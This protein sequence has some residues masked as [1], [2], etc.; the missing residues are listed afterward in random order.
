MI[1][2]I[3]THTF[4]DKIASSVI[5]Q[6]KSQS[7]TVPFTDG[8]AC[9]LAASM[10][11]A[12]V[13]LS[14]I[15]S[16]ATSPKQVEHI[17]NSSLENNKSTPE[18][19]LLFFGCI[20]PD[21]PGWEKELHRIHEA[22]LAGIKIH[23]VYQRTAL[24]DEKFLR[25]LRLC[26]ELDLIVIAHM[27]IDIG[28]PDLSF[29]T[30]EMARNALDK[31]GPFKLVLAHM[32]GWREWDRAE[33]MLADTPAFLD[34]SFS[35]GVMTPLDDGYYAPEDLLLM[36][37]EEF[38]GMA[39]AFGTDR[40]LFGTDSPWSP[41]KESIEWIRSLPLSEKEKAAILGGNAGK[42]LGV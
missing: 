5:N 13:D 20:H 34:T 33:K 40:L 26:A 30:P 6:L 25:I 21:Y 31:I 7:H 42:L 2:D 12:G 19:G 39:K 32:G 16:V 35:T 15:L 23:P 14:V 4:P 24:D 28:Y 17:N 22:G 41:Q 10:H 11:K 1:I 29:C 37:E 36:N 8:T 3:H 18:T 27:G 9:G 38:L